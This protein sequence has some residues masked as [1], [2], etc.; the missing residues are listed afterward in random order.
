MRGF[1]S[2]LPQYAQVPRGRNEVY[3]FAQFDPTRDV[4]AAGHFK[5]AF[6][7][8]NVVRISPPMPLIYA[9]APVT[10]LA[11]HVQIGR[12]HV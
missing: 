2:A 4:D 11:S 8:M 12:A 7:A 9:G 6:E 1:G 3:R 10:R 5:P